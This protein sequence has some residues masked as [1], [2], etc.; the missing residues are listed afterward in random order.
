M[1]YSRDGYGAAGITTFFPWLLIDNRPV[2]YIS[3]HHCAFGSTGIAT[4]TQIFA[5]IFGE[6][7]ELLQYGK[8]DIK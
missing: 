2:G 1:I 6:R 5:K 3:E 8:F 7:N 4:G